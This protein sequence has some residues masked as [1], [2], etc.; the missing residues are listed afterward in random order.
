MGL[1]LEQA[2]GLSRSGLINLRERLEGRES[3]QLGLFSTFRR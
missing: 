3:D 2:K 1:G